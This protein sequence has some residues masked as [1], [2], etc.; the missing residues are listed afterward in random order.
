[1]LVNYRGFILCEKLIG[2]IL[3]PNFNKSCGNRD[4]RIQESPIYGKLSRIREPVTIVQIP[5]IEGLE[6]SILGASGLLW[7]YSVRVPFRDSGISDLL[8]AVPLR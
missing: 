4:I 6:R 7:G 5:G 1:M 2:Q 8:R 3:I